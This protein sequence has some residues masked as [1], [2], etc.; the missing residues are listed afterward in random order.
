VSTS[1]E[2]LDMRREA[3]RGD[4]IV[5]RSCSAFEEVAHLAGVKLH[6]LGNFLLCQ[7]HCTGLD[8]QHV[9]SDPSLCQ[10]PVLHQI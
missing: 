7:R 6:E 4:S 10:Q 1:T 8:Y 9:S 2:Y 3:S 5:R